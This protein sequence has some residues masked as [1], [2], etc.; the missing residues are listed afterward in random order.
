MSSLNFNSLKVDDSG[1]V[2]FS[3]LSSGI[4][5]QG[6]VDSIIAARKIPVDTLQ[7]K[8]TDN[9]DK[10]SALQDLRNLLGTFQNSMAK[11]YGQV[12]F[13]SAN[14]IF[15]GKQAFASSTRIDGSSPSAAGNLLGV[16]VANSAS[17]GSHTIEVL[18]T[19][20]AHKVSSDLV[21]DDTAALGLT[22]G[23]TFTINGVTI[24]TDANDS[25]QDLR[26]RI[27]N[28]NTGGS[29][30]G[31]TASIVAVSAS[32]HY[33]LLTADQTGT[34]ITLAD[35][36]GTPLES[37]G[38]LNGGAIKNELQ[39]AQ[40][41]KMYADGL[42]DQT[43]TIYESSLQAASTTQIG[44]SG[45]LTFT[46]DSDSAPLGTI[47][48]NSTDSL[49]DLADA[50]NAGATDVTAS[51]V[52]DGGG[53]RLEISAVAG[54]SI[55][56]S[57][58]GSAI[59]DL[60]I[61]NKRL[62][63]TRSSN[64]VDDLFAGVTL[65]LFQA[66][67]GTTVT[68]DIEKDLSA[69]KTAIANVVD[70]YNALR[71]FINTNHAINK[72]TGQAA[73]N[74]GVLFSSPALAEVTQK[75]N[76]IFGQ[77]AQGVNADYQV[78]SQIGINFVDINQTDP[79]L[80]QNLEIDETK[81]DAALLNNPDDVRRLFAFD[82][83][84]SDPRVSLLGFN[85][86]TTYSASGYTLNIQPASG[87]NM[88]QYSEQADNAYWTTSAATVSADATTAPDG[89]AT[90]DGLVG[91]A[92]LGTHYVTNA[93]PETVTAGSNYIY[94]T[95]VKAGDK[96]QVRIAFNG[97]GFGGA[98]V[99]ADFDLTAGTVIGADA[100]IDATSIENVGNGW[101]RVGIKAAAA[102]SG[103]AYVET[104]ARDNALGTSFSGDAATVNTYVFGA[105]LQEVT[106]ETAPG[107]YIATTNAARLGVVASANINGPAD[108]S[109]DG[110]VTVNGNKL[111]VNNGGAQGLQL[112]QSGLSFTNSIQLDF[113]VGIGSEF[114]FAA[115]Q[116]LDPTTG[117]VD[118][119]LDQLTDQN[120]LNQDRIDEMLARLDVQ[121]QSLLD[122][123]IKM[124]TAIA[125][126]N[127]VMDSITSITD[128]LFKSQQK[129]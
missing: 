58:A 85:G 6:A 65:S 93:A 114:Y 78:L 84:S 80:S 122:R 129:N 115:D 128:A 88:L 116:M 92:T 43:N 87:D 90:A 120:K 52:T 72:T 41:A 34:S 79:L 13:G 94:S 21:V 20:K 27:N 124:E 61:N 63:I 25:L 50:I 51:V 86:S 2:T 81:L 118:G 49:Q 67:K 100:G 4:D 60:G 73:D 96:D 89:N 39:A 111:T 104:Y 70:S 19:A 62:E 5:F 68:L 38:I 64:T 95:Y 59:T 55:S 29:A 56:E 123:F 22:T 112:F 119:E 83:A 18:Q 16:T 48:Y 71:Q 30:T 66:E 8:I 107:D 75:L 44:S 117:T 74:A 127:R 97:A 125:N 35:T 57:G 54:T 69:V 9:Q 14:D 46:R 99:G 37:I 12:S 121:R 36:G 113:T 102:A 126:A 24:T 33:L 17:A 76:N 110:S 53:V 82:F 98:S 26:D 103:D 91:D 23:D 10:I 105:Q 7:T 45:S 15:A 3:G 28:A 31:V 106:T 47:A 1:H 11:L 108:G 40:S 42:L 101:Y 77:G 32:E 109:D